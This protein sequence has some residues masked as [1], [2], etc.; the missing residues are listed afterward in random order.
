MIEGLAENASKKQSARR[1]RYTRR[2]G[3]QVPAR[4]AVL[5]FGCE[6]N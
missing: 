2:R 3:Q 5:D 4:L 1:H 6:K